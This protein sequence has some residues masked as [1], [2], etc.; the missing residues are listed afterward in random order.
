VAA[1]SEALDGAAQVRFGQI[2]AAEVHPDQVRVDQVG[3]ELRVGRAPLVPVAGAEPVEVVGV[4][5]ATRLPL[6]V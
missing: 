5:H 2:Q 1:S 4:R 3:G 6:P